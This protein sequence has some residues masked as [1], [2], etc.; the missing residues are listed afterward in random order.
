MDVLNVGVQDGILLNV[1][2]EPC[3]KDETGDGIIC[4][5]TEPVELDLMTGKKIK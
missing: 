2:F 4:S 5:Y 1:V 3:D